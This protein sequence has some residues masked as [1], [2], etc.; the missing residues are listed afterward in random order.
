MHTTT[1]TTTFGTESKEKEEIRIFFVSDH[2]AFERRVF[3]KNSTVLQHY[4]HRTTAGGTS[5]FESAS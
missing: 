3:K 4:K 5:F 1:T 2:L